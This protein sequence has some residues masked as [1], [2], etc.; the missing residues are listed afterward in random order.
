M[1]FSNLF[2][3]FLFL[4]LNLIC[5][6]LA[7]S[8]KSKN[9]V[10]LLFSL[11]FYAWGEPVYVF[12]LIGMAFVDW[13]LSRIIDANRGRPLA[14]AALIVSLCVSLGLLG[15][16]KYTGLVLDTFH[17]LFGIPSAIPQIALPIGISFYTF[18]LISYVIDVYRGEV[19]AQ[20]KFWLLLMYISLFHQCIAGPIVRYQDVNREILSRQPTRQEISRGI[21]RFCTGLAKKALLANSCGALADSLILSDAAASNAAM[22]SQNIAVLSSRP[23]LSLW[24]GVFAF[25]LQIYLDFSAYSDMAIGMGLMIGF[26]YKENFDYPYLSKS[27]S[28]FWRRWH[29][30]LGSFFRDYVYFPLGGSRCSRGRMVLNLLVVWFLTGLWHGA[31]W[32]F[33]LWGLYF[34]LFIALEKLF[35]GRILQKIPPAFSHIYLLLIVF[36]GWALFRFRQPALLGTVLRGMFCLNGNPAVSFESQIIFLNYIFFLIAAVIAVTPLLKSIGS[37]WEWRASLRGG[38]ICYSTVQVL[39]P[40]LLLLLSTAALVGNSYNPFLY[41]QF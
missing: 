26:H 10:M 2:F 11:F 13:F 33:V 41:F 39:L 34:F 5:Y 20:K 21:S 14:K 18:Q 7:G 32:N 37:F 27:V 28:E 1:V 30:S 9:I 3:L 15:V 40:P 12:L 31:S 16:F 22:L 19:R 23:A 6:Y 4:P 36:F 25:M 8:I 24:L 29:I 38:T 35:L 17:Q